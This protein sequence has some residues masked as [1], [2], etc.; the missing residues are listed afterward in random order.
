MLCDDT[1]QFG[2]INVP[3]IRAGIVVRSFFPYNKKNSTS[4]LIVCP[5]DGGSKLLRNVWLPTRPL[6]KELQPRLH[7]P[8]IPH[9]ER[10]CEMRFLQPSLRVLSS[11]LLHQAAGLLIPRRF[12]GTYRLQTPEVLPGGTI[13]RNVGNNTKLQFTVTSQKTPELYIKGSLRF[14]LIIPSNLNLGERSDFSPSY[15]AIIKFPMRST[16][17]VDFTLF[18][19]IIPTL[20]CE[21]STSQDRGMIILYLWTLCLKS[22]FGGLGVACW[23]LVPKFEGFKPGRSR[24]IFRTKKSSAR[25]PSEGK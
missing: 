11:G 25:L 8:I 12:K 16:R 23:P 7:F 1:V 24:R 5:A 20:N 13:F 21:M 14:I 6:P 9:T 19:T 17:P 3:D 10:G 4:W 15:F 2:R 18:G 22:G